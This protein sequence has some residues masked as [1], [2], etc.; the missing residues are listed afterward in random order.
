[1]YPNVP[2]GGYG[3]DN[4]NGRRVFEAL[5]A[6]LDDGWEI[7]Q[8]A[9]M[10][11]TGYPPADHGADDD[12]MDWTAH[13]DRLSDW[14]DDP[15]SDLPPPPP[16]PVPQRRDLSSPEARARVDAELDGPGTTEMV[17]DGMSWGTS[18]GAMQFLLLHAGRPAVYLEVHSS[19]YRQH[20]GRWYSIS[21]YG[22]NI[23]RPDPLA[24]VTCHRDQVA[25][26]LHQVLRRPLPI[27]RALVAPETELAE[28]NLP[29]GTPH[30]AVVDGPAVERIEGAIDRLLAPDSRRRDECP[31]A[32]EIT[33]IRDA[34][35]P[36]VPVTSV[37][38][39]TADQMPEPI[40]LTR[41]QSAVLKTMSTSIRLIVSG[42][43]GSGKTETALAHARRQ[44]ARGRRVAYVCAGFELRSR[45]WSAVDRAVELHTF[46]SL[47]R[48]TIERAG[49]VV[50]GPPAPELMRWHLTKELP[51]LMHLACDELGPEFDD[52][53][54]DD[55]NWFTAEQLRA[56]LR[57]ARHWQ[58][59]QAWFFVDS[60]L[61]SPAVDEV[62]GEPRRPAL[63]VRHH[64][65]IDP[66]AVEVID[67][68]DQV[69]CV[70]DLVQRLLERDGV[71]INDLVVITGHTLATSGVTANPPDGL[72]YGV[73]WE[74]E[75]VVRLTEI[76]SVLGIFVPVVI[77]CE[78]D[79]LGGDEYDMHVR[80]G[81]A[82]ASERCI[83]VRTKH[84]GR[85]P[86]A[87]AAAVVRIPY[88]P[89][90]P[91]RLRLLD[92]R[93]EPSTQTWRRPPS[94]TRT[95]LWRLEMLHAP[96]LLTQAEAVDRW[97]AHNTPPPELIT[98][99]RRHD[100]IDAEREAA[101]RRRR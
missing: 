2:L 80:A 91:F 76:R 75:D 90:P 43:A 11:I 16:P 12:N 39:R 74:S 89:N 26:L 25:D 22:S 24:S 58:T 32:D 65:V 85:D 13:A 57:A 81:A 40:M 47:C 86:A 4:G 18:Y 88:R 52:I 48:Q 49:Y 14:D 50:P 72:E 1:M 101:L 30:G 60:D 15:G 69:A 53:Y 61:P 29:S 94:T 82:R 98:D 36:R 3:R 34:L 63:S 78:L 55:A 99:L 83:L 54:I 71:S 27:R 7:H 84:A 9:G 59:G 73:W 6:R 68:D 44:A 19:R 67:S 64:D 28:I 51:A 77:L 45:M 17:G 38:R 20:N 66:K 70:G 5:R 56:A 23:R 62:N 95:L 87:S 21:D 96:D 10:V 37:L 93:H 100:L 8:T 79:H 33:V 31:T 42:P 41:E 35:A 46:P 97:L 92:P